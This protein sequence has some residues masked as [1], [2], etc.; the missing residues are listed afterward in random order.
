MYSRLVFLCILN[1]LFSLV[2][3]GQVKIRLFSSG[4][5]ESAI[6]TALSGQYELDT[7]NGDKIK[8]DKNDP[9]LITR[10]KG[11]LAVKTLHLKGFICDSLS[12]E[13][14][15]GNDSFSLRINGK[16]PQRKYYSGDLTCL[17]DLGTLLF[18]NNCDV[19]SYIS[20]VVKAEG[21]S[22]WSREYFKSQAILART[23]MY[24]YFD[25]HLSDKYNVCDN[26]HCQAFNGISQD[27]VINRAVLDTKGLVILDSDSSLII[28]AFHSNCGG[29]TSSSEFVWLKSQPYLKSVVDPYCI[30]ARNARWEK[31][32][33]LRDWK[34]MITKSGYDV[35][36]IDPSSYSFIQNKRQESY[37]AG[38]FSI[39]LRNIRT[40]MNLKSTFFSVS[41]D[42]DSVLLI[43]R[44]YGHGVG[45]CQE[46]AM[47]MAQQG[48]TYRQIISFYYSGVMIADVKN[49]VITP[50]Q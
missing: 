29:E 22:G 41:V 36:S 38:S 30:S 1:V 50:D 34:G 7:F 44:G 26:T 28:S 45:L 10:F 8:I 9:V 11:K 5:P 37:T 2:S 43:G 35:Q 33:S 25:K 27:G 39:P 19:E 6:F 18:I 20:G 31:K 21:G 48:L 4:S 15:T 3:F 14:D 49:V 32:I 17:P 16:T 12:F 24:K 23:Y 46:G 13:G 42:G 47:E 40:E